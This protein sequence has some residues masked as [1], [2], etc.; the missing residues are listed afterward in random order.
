M[1]NSTLLPIYFI[2]FVFTFIA[3]GNNSL[4]A[5]SGIGFGIGAGKPMVNDLLNTSQSF[6]LSANK[7]ISGYQLF[8]NISVLGVGL[9]Y[10]YDFKSFTLNSTTISNFEIKSDTKINNFG[11]FFPLNYYPFVFFLTFEYG[12]GTSEITCNS[13]ICESYLSEPEIIN[14]KQI[15]FKTRFLLP[16]A[17][18]GI[19]YHRMTGAKSLSYLNGTSE[20][21]ILDSNMYSISM[22]FWF[23][24]FN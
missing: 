16:F 3:L 18:V 15:V 9:E 17:I 2:F 4:S 12:T 1:K 19:G 20:D 22:E 13:A 11:F 21:L 10:G 14:V 23:N 7:N 24:I 8:T 6:K 5:H